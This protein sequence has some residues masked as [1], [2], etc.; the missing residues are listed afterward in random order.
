MSV[1]VILLFSILISRDEASASVGIFEKPR[2]A[3]MD[4][5]RFGLIK[6]WNAKGKDAQIA[7]IRKL[8]APS[9]VTIAIGNRIPLNNFDQWLQELDRNH[10]PCQCALGPSEIRCWLILCRTSPLS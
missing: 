3:L 8:Q 5:T 10:R 4:Q 6:E 9:N 7:A 2:S 1:S